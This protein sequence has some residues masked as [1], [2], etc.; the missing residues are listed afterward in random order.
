MHCDN[1]QGNLDL[2]VLMGNT[3]KGI[4]SQF[5][6]QKQLPANQPGKKQKL[7]KNKTEVI[8]SKG[9][10]GSD[11]DAKPQSGSMVTDASGDATLSS[12][13]ISGLCPDECSPTN[14]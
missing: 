14:S 13:S 7:W 4:S 1:V 2:E 10:A 6:K 3:T 12:D 9:T 11:V 5:Q 8:V